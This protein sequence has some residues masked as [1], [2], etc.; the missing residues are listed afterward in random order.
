MTPILTLCQEWSDQFLNLTTCKYDDIYEGILGST[1]NLGQTNPDV[2]HAVTT[3]M[4][5]HIKDMLLTTERYDVRG[6]LVT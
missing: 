3:R 4:F 1:I 2:I 5:P 6:S